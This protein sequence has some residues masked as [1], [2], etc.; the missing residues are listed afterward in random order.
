MVVVK[1]VPETL[2][3]IVSV[4]VVRSAVDVAEDCGQS[5]LEGREV[6]GAKVR[7]GVSIARVFLGYSGREVKVLELWD[8]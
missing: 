6:V 1:G 8:G 3:R 2:R 4:E 5:G 7:K